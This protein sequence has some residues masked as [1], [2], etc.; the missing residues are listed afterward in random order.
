MLRGGII[1]FGRMGLTHYSILNNHPDVNFVS[2]CDSSSF[3]LRNLRKHI[4]I[5]TF[6][7]YQK[8]I[9]KMNLDFVI[10]ATPTIYHAE[11]IKYAI[12]NDVHIFVEK[13]FTLNPQEG[14]EIV[15]MLQGT[16]LVNQVG[17]VIRFSDVFLKVK[18]FLSSGLIGDL[19]SFKMEMYGPTLLKSS[20]SSWRSKRESGGGCLYDFASHS[21][22]MINYLMGP[23]KK[24]V[25]SVLK[26]IYSAS[27]ED[28]VS[29]TF[30]YP[31][32]LSGVLMANWSE[33]SYRKTNFRIEL[34]GKDGKII[35]D[36]HTIKLFLKE[37]KEGGEL[38]EGWNTLYVTDFGKPVRFYVRGGEFTSQLDYFIGCVSNG[39]PGEICDFEDGL[40]TDT[41]MDMIFSDDS[42]RSEIN[43]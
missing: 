31:N 33:A 22:D 39:R 29:S 16:K 28:A 1:G 21:V 41:T 30:I 13:P 38:T 25:G 5:E 23:P 37:D 35:A 8:M 34:F 18:E 9:D 24:V 19:L 3:M 15:D 20:K 36:M 6:E 17:Y 10:I 4:D 42:A 43:G 32:N 14:R 26:S 40:S 2:V 7:D 27:V 11:A 12:K